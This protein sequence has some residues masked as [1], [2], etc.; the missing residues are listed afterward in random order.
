MKNLDLSTF[1]HINKD[2]WIKYAEKQL[3]GANPNDELR[4]ENDG[5]LKL[6]GYYD[7][8]DVSDLKYLENFFGNLPAHKWKLY[9]RVL[10]DDPKVAN[11]NALNALM[12]GCDGVILDNPMSDDLNIILEGI[13]H[14]ICDVNVISAHSLSGINKLTGFELSPAG[15]CLQ[16][17]EEK[18]PV[19]QLAEA[20]DKITNETFIYR[21][22][23]TDF[24]LEIA[25]VRS[26]RYLL[27]LKGI[28]EIHIH[29]QIPLHTS[30]EQQWFL[31][32]TGGLASILGGSHS[33]DFTT[34][35]GDARISRN[36]G[37]LIRE[38][39]GIEEYNDQCGGS[40]YIEV[41]THKIIQ[42]VSERA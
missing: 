23:H 2:E 6:E 42:K 28:R 30:Y 21:F 11:S 37:N 34:A 13:N 19:V 20:L 18:N 27:D 8:S 41:L 26:L 12:G 29:T 35:T 39:S 36:V 38:E 14:E 3:K 16:L 22:A 4:W 40:Y 7:Y 31:N 1:P 17:L 24:F 9:E 25:T 5:K 32:T 33:V 10:T 15:N